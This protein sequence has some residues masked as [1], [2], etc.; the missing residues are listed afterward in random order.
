[1]RTPSRLRMTFQSEIPPEKYPQKMKESSFERPKFWPRNE[2]N[3]ENIFM[4][5]IN[6]IHNSSIN[7]KSTKPTFHQPVIT[8]KISSNKHSKSFS[9][10]VKRRKKKNS[11]KKNVLAEKFKKKHN[12]GLWD[13]QELINISD[14][15]SQRGNVKNLDHMKNK[16]ILYWDRENQQIG[17]LLN[18]QQE[19]LATFKN[20]EEK[21]EKNFERDTKIE[22]RVFKKSNST[23]SLRSRL[24]RMQRENEV[25]LKKIYQKNSENSSIISGIRH[26]R[27]ESNSVVSFVSHSNH[28]RNISFNFDKK[29]HSRH[30][31]NLH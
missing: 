28:S 11:T 4:N 16:K 21:K 20:L 22:K 27:K 5:K 15:L 29:S 31:I 18:N 1:M 9:H 14:I 10:S 3:K 8:K 19:A 17:D 30:T 6:S 13:N 23:E 26:K 12:I 24:E 7:F 25:K 2:E